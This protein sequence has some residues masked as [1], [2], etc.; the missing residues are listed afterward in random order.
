MASDAQMKTTIE[1]P[2]E[3]YRRAKAEAAL[4]GRKLR[5]LVEE[6]LRLVL[7]APRK[8]RRPPSLAG[9][10]RRA[11]GMIDS[12]VPDLASNPEHLAGFGRDARRH[13]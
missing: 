4:Q 8:T 1:V 5:D 2:D 3:L 11:R 10:T 9:L 7:E 6:G 13:R 12:G